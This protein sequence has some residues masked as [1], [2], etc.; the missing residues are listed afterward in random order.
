MAQPSLH[1]RTF[2]MLNRAVDTA[3]LADQV[4]AQPAMLLPSVPRLEARHGELA[5]RL[6]HIAA[7]GVRHEDQVR[8]PQAHLLQ[9]SQHGR[10]IRVVVTQGPKLGSIDG[11]HEEIAEQL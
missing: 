9:T 8:V 10:V 11:G 3:M 6:R 7:E 5:R 4:H 2:R 1:A